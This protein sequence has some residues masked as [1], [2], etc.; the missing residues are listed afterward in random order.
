M[1]TDYDFW[2]ERVEDLLEK[3][4]RFEKNENPKVSVL[5]GWLE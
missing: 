2:V 3:E 4:P 1:K 5:K